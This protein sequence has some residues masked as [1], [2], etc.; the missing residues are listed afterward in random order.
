MSSSRNIAISFKLVY[1][2]NPLCCINRLPMLSRELALKPRTEN[3]I[4]EFYGIQSDLNLELE[5]WRKSTEYVYRSEIDEISTR[6]ALSTTANG[7]DTLQRELIRASKNEARNHI[8]LVSSA[9]QNNWVSSSES[10]SC[11]ALCIEFISIWSDREI[12]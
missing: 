9:S 10:D 2:H 3:D 7:T 11:E 8:L 12:I 4:A 1:G 6:E 5:R